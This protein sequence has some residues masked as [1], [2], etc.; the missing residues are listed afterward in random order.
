MTSPAP[1]T[2]LGT[3]I[4]AISS[5]FLNTAAFIAS[6]P[7]SIARQARGQR[8]LLLYQLD[9]VAVGILDERDGRGP[10][11]H[12]AGFAHDVDAFLFEIGAGCVDVVDAEGDVSVGGADF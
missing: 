2:G 4:T 8:L 9:L 1:A 11:L 6:Q 10:V 3:S 12:R 7:F 5:L